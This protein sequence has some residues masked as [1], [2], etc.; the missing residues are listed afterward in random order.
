MKETA[1]SNCPV[2]RCPQGK[3]PAPKLHPETE[4]KADR[5]PEDGESS[6]TEKPHPRFAPGSRGF[7]VYK[8]SGEL[9]IFTA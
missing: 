9:V 2:L 3:G 1:S 4:A 7:Q 5:K 8:S 6:E